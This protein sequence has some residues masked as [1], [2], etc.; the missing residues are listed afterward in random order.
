MCVLLLLLL[1]LLLL[2]VCGQNE[3]EASTTLTYSHSSSFCA[4]SLYYTQA[5]AHTYSHT[6]W[7]QQT[8]EAKSGYCHLSFLYFLFDFIRTHVKCFISG[9]A[10][11]TWQVATIALFSASEQTHCALVVC[12]SE[13]VTVALHSMF[14]MSTEVVTVLFSCWHG[15]CLWNSQVSMKCRH[16]CVDCKVFDFKRVT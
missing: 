16:S 11:S 4:M 15:W 10:L 12:D 5:H 7:G 6:I 8:D 13:W 1:L 9:W 3:F 2:C 14:L